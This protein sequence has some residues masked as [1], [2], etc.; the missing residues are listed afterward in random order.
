[1]VDMG[2]LKIF[3]FKNTTATPNSAPSEKELPRFKKW[4]LLRIFYNNK[5]Y[6]FFPKKPCLLQADAAFS[7]LIHF[8]SQLC[9]VDFDVTF[10]GYKNL[11]FNFRLNLNHT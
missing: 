3:Q 11:M 6:L 10:Q 2:I 1:M 4:L 8:L 5:K 9:F 7:R